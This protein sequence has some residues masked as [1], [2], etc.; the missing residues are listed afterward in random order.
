[1]KMKIFVINLDADIDRLE[2]AN[3]Q[4]IKHGYQF[5]RIPGVDGRKMAI[6][7]QRKSV[8]Y[9]R[10]WCI[11]GKKPYLGEIGCALSHLNIYKKMDEENISFACILEDDIIVLDGFKSKLNQLSEWLD[12][13]RPQVVRLNFS[14]GVE[15]V[16]ELGNVPFIRSV[17]DMSAC[18]Y[19]LTLEAARALLKHNYP[20][21]TV[22]DNWPRWTKLELI[23]LYDLNQKVCWHNNVASG[24]T[25]RA[26]C[27]GFTINKFHSILKRVYHKP[28]RLVGM[29]LDRILILT[30]C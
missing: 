11:N 8:N 19:C 17:K 30:R 23:E 4:S 24:F 15:G 3:A 28:L 20:I 12:K 9:F 25:T 18:S 26:G 14:R 22:A 21:V 1:M 29:T 2:F 27:K 10:Y 13:D 5:T 6:Q 7:E 16:S